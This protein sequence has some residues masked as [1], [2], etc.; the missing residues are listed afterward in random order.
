M[1]MFR[2]Q[3]TMPIPLRTPPPARGSPAAARGV[4][5]QPGR[6]R[7]P[8]LGALALAAALLACDQ[9]RGTAPGTLDAV[10]IDRTVDSVLYV[11]ESVDL[12][13][14]ALDG[15]RR[16]M[17]GLT[18]SIAWQSD[19]EDVVTVDAASGVVVAQGPGTAKVRAQVQGESAEITFQVSYAVAT[20]EL[21]LPTGDSVRLRDDLRACAVVRSS[22]GVEITDGDVTWATSDP[23]VLSL[24]PTVARCA[25]F[26]GEK[27]G[28]ANV[29]AQIGGKRAEATVR[30]V[31][32]VASL[33]V[34]DLPSALVAGECATLEVVPRDESGAALVR[35]ITYQSSDSR[36]VTVDET[37][38]RACWE[39]EG[40]ATLTA[41]SEGVSRQ[42]TARVVP[43]P[44]TVVGYA[45]L[46]SDARRAFRW[47]EAGGLQQLPFLPG[48][49]S[50]IAKGVN[51]NG[52]IVGET[53]TTDGVIH[54]FIYT[55]GRGIRE[56]PAPASATGAEA[57]AINN[58]G[59][60]GG[61]A[62]FAD[63]SQRLMVWA[64]AG[65]AIERFDRGNA[66]GARKSN[67]E[68]LNLTGAI[69]GTG[70]DESGRR[71][72]Y[73]ATAGGTYGYLVDA[74]GE[75]ASEAKGINYVGD[76]AGYY[77]DADGFKRPFLALSGSQKRTLDVPLGCREA[78][79]YG[80]DNVGRSVVTAL[81]CP[82]GDRSYVR[83]TN[84]AYTPLFGANTQA[85]AMN[86]HGDVVGWTLVDGRNQAYLWR[87]GAASGTLLGRFGDGQRSNAL[88]LNAVR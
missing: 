76:I 25:T 5:R 22:E 15:S 59:Q 30:V 47:T 60:V 32:R 23:E 84:G 79:A 72:A 33:S 88:A 38:G 9:S 48:A 53:L 85:R 46:E 55:P 78:V 75:R 43:A 29:S 81:G 69:A 12:R 64:V 61:S 58:S 62:F 18:Q 49:V 1:R 24:M 41:E 14:V 6:R 42:V 44:F 65:D 74:P 57:K 28:L 37:G 8:L 52:Q 39:S 70:I 86:E 16:E 4:R 51:D 54:A 68:G 67:V 73:R 40:T 77:E 80:I 50:A 17:V 34:A 21:L 82:G 56:L 63:G 11:G 20:V 3:S 35:V 26:R 87:R 71:R 31:N 45:D 83:G 10:V 13:A 2:T 19:D 7:R 27:K 36:V 66:P